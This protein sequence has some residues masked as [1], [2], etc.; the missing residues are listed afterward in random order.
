[1]TTPYISNIIVHMT[2]GPEV[3]FLTQHLRK[4][5]RRI[6]ALRAKSEYPASAAV[7]TVAPNGEVLSHV[8]YTAQPDGSIVGRHYEATEHT[9]KLPSGSTVVAQGSI[10]ITMP[11]P[12]ASQK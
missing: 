12:P 4:T 8:G 5:L 11:E 7:E 1:M 6:Q 10:E 3:N 9:I 2:R